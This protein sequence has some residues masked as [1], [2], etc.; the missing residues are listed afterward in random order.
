MHGPLRHCLDT[1]DHLVGP[2]RRAAHRAAAYATLSAHHDRPHR[3]PGLLQREAQGLEPVLGA[4]REPARAVMSVHAD[5][6]HRLVDLLQV[7]VLGHDHGAACLLPGISF[8]LGRSLPVPQNQ[9]IVSAGWLASIH[10]LEPDL[11]QP[12]AEGLGPVVGLATDA[13]KGSHVLMATCTAT[14]CTARALNFCHCSS[15]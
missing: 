14:T 4:D 9:P 6:V 7:A 5:R 1:L 12:L 11:L 10:E 8:Q 2:L 3:R 15:M 13:T